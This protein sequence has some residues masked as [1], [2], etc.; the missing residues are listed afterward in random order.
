MISSA[1]CSHVRDLCQ[2]GR[3]F[4]RRRCAWYRADVALSSGQKDEVGGTSDATPPIARFRNY[5]PHTDELKR[6]VVERGRAPFD[7]LLEEL[8][9]EDDAAFALR[10]VR[11][12]C[13]SR[14]G[15]AAL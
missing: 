7:A 14:L 1:Q 13:V 15:V 10:D 12:R 5:V 6:G 11:T 4:T 8:K 2:R 9:S 3:A